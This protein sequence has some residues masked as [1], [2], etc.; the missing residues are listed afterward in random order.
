MVPTTYLAVKLAKQDK[1]PLAASLTNICFLYILDK[2]Q[3]QEL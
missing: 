1:I 2:K 3:E